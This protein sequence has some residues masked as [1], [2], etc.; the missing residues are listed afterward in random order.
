MSAASTSSSQTIRAAPRGILDR[1]RFLVR[2]YVLAEG[3]AVTLAVL[4][5]AFW[6]SFLLDR[7]LELPVGWRIAILIAA[8]VT[9]GLFVL[10]LVVQRAFREY[11]PRA[12]ALIL[13]RKYPQFDDRLITTV[14]LA[15]DRSRVRTPLSESMLD[16]TALELRGMLS[17]VRLGDVF[18]LGPL[19]RA[20]TIAVLLLLSIG[21]FAAVASDSARLW[22]RRNVLL[23][24]EFWPRETDLVVKVLADPGERVIP[25]KNGLYKHPQGQNLS[26]VAEVPEGKVV[27]DQVQLVY[28]LEGGGGATENLAR[29]GDRSFRFTLSG[30]QA[31]ARLWFYGGDYSSRRPYLVQVVAPPQINRMRLEA[32]YPRYTGKSPE[33]LTVS[34]SQVS[35][36]AATEFVLRAETNKPM[37]GFRLAS[38]TFALEVTKEKVVLRQPPDGPEQSWP[39]SR[40]LLSSKG[41]SLVV[42]CVLSTKPAEELAG[43][44]GPVVPLRLPPTAQLSLFLHDA[45]DV[46]SVEPTRL[47]VNSMADEP[48]SI[49]TE[50][51]GVGSA[52]TRQ[53]T[54]PVEGTVQD[55]YGV[56]G[57]RFDF[58]LD[59]QTFWEP[60]MFAAPTP[61]GREVKV[62]ERFELLP[63]DLKIGQKLTLTVSAGDAY[64]PLTL[65][66]IDPLSVAALPLSL[67]THD[68][69]DLTGP[70]RV[71]GDRYTFEVV[72]NE[73]LSGTDRRP[74]TQPAA[75]VRADHQRGRRD[76]P[77][78]AA[79]AQQ[80]RRVAGH[81]GRRGPARQGLGRPVDRGRA[82]GL[83]ERQEP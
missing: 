36:P 35:L 16:K 24:N 27:P 34:G 79:P 45:D 66:S 78:P 18:N 58:R 4:G 30:L 21:T 62:A 31:S 10:T 59:A 14:E 68:V 54:V 22:F 3:T 39:I 82:V 50:L 23:K 61:P 29:V 81:L 72:T 9:S 20:V 63:L 12:L 83:P 51:R 60:K 42:P 37:Q 41:T 13:E 57:P 53:A 2:S 8:V 55:D 7:T 52:V 26:I 25:F 17:A 80:A 64:E 46:M 77:R 67:F 11:S 65:F 19:V 75:A 71:Q 6:V 48:P 70:H 69:D 32:Q 33:V 28:R 40:S 47:T 1:L 43:L 49:K 44:R 73:E 56:V 74:G 76:P 38:D 5:A 15:E